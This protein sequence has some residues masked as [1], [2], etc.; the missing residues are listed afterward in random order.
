MAAA[1]ALTTTM[2]ALCSH[3]LL[4]CC[5]PLFRRRAAGVYSKRSRRPPS[6]GIIPVAI[7]PPV[8][9]HIACC[10]ASAA[11]VSRSVGLYAV[12]WHD[13]SPPP[14]VRR[15]YSSTP[16][17]NVTPTATCS[18]HLRRSVYSTRL[19]SSDLISPGLNSTRQFR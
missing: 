8:H 11:P 12:D 10:T 7:T 9:R 17:Q 6:S 5:P 19:I 1:V 14:V 4:V 13:L 3:Q 15:I 2:S 18:L 16:A